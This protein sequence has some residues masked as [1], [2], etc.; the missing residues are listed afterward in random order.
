MT[1]AK[2][3]KLA[4]C[5][6]HSSPRYVWRIAWLKVFN[7]RCGIVGDCIQTLTLDYAPETVTFQLKR[8]TATGQKLMTDIAIPEVIFIE[9][10]KGVSNDYCFLWIL[11]G[12]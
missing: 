2:S 11:M 1:S 5:F 8:F 10:K 6:P 9:N 4:R 3:Y 12:K 7:S